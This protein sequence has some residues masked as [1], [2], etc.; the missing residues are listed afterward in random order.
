M[1][2]VLSVDRE[3]AVL[4]SARTGNLWL[5]HIEISGVGFFRKPRNFH[6]WR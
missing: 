6:R 2:V 5:S 3:N 4:G 1:D